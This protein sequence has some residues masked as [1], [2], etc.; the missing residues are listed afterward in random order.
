M[1]FVGNVGPAAAVAA[2]GP[3][4]AGRIFISNSAQQT[5]KMT[6]ILSFAIVHEQCKGVEDGKDKT[7]LSREFS[8]DSDIRSQQC[9]G[10]EKMERAAV[11]NMEDQKLEN[12]L[13]LSLEA[14]RE[15]REKSPALREGYDAGTRR[16][17]LIVKYSGGLDFL[18]EEFPEIRVWPLLGGYAV[19][20]VPESQIEDLSR[21]SQIEYIEKPKRLFFSVNRAKQ[22]ACIT[23]VQ[24]AGWQSQWENAPGNAES[25]RLPSRSSALTGRGVLVAVLDSGIDYF[26]KDFRDE[27]GKSRILELWD[28]ERDAVYSREEIDAA[29]AAG[30]REAAYRLVPVRDVSGHG[31]AVAGIAAGG[32]GESGGVYRGVANESELLAV[33]LGTP[34]AGGFPRT[35]ELMRAVDF[36][37]RRAAS[38]G[39]PLAVNVSIGNTYGSHD[40][41]SLLETYLDAAALTGRTVICVGSGNEGSA[42]GHTSGF[43]SAKPGGGAEVELSVGPYE[44][45][46]GVQLWKIYADEFDVE[47]VSPGGISSGVISQ[48]LGSQKLIFPDTTVLL[49]Y[50]NPSPYSQAQEIYFDFIPTDQYVESGIWKFRLLPHRI[51]T[52]QYDFW[53]PSESALNRATRFLAPTPDTTLTI[54]ATAPRVITVAAYDDATQ[55]YADFS[56]RG[57]TRLGHQMKPDL[58]APGVNIVTARAGGGYEA[59]TGTSFAAP[60]VTGSAALMMQWGIVDGNDPYLY[61]EKVKAYLQRGARELPGFKEFPNPQVGYGALCLQESFPG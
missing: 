56:G 30:S 25:D 57:Y 24:R 33:K 16:W 45:G 28:Q 34:Q 37:V 11:D 27:T 12:L 47:L 54:P 44:T 55:T 49:Y 21:F 20:S 7:K 3:V 39:R 10:I 42:M 1:Y 5:S 29:L 2:A 46:F 53:L 32:G 14:D 48:R 23:A 52:G 61:G 18:E 8:Q 41:T 9:I 43:L 51:V 40:G 26:H 58:A 35:T 38:L 13:N 15:E 22:D 17:D 4:C 50:G 36:A 6:S 19:L 59:V 31:T 60:F